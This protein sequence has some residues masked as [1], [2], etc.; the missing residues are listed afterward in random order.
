[1]KRVQ[2]IK[3]KSSIILLATI[4]ILVLITFVPS[5]F[6]YSGTVV[7]ENII[8]TYGSQSGTLD[9]I[10]YEDNDYVQWTGVSVFWLQYK[11]KTR[12]YFEEKSDVGT[13]NEL[14]IEF[15]FNGGNVIDIVI[16][17]TDTSYDIHVE[18]SASWKT[19]IYDLD[20]YKI[21]DYVQF[22]NHEYWNPGILK[23]DYIEVNY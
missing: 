7:P 9:D 21:V 10:K 5:T 20:N 6:A 23:V 1:M 19:V 18:S 12:I 17:Y 8:N 22:Y 11:I 16:K 2:K 4:G 3:H 13:G 15:A 14:E